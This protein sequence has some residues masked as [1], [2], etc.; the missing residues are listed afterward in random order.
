MGTDPCAGTSASNECGAGAAGHDQRA[1]SS[2]GHAQACLEGGGHRRRNI[3]AGDVRQGWTFLDRGSGGRDAPHRHCRAGIDAS[4]RGGQRRAPST[5]RSARRPVRPARSTTPRWSRSAQPRATSS[6]RT[7]RRRFLP[8]RSSRSS[9]RR[10]SVR[11]SSASRGW[12]SARSVRVHRV[13]VIRGL[14]G[15]RV[16][17]LEDGQ[18]VGDLS[19]QSGDHGVTLNPASASPHRS[20]AWPR[21]SP[22]RRER[23]RGS[24]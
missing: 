24:R 6:S 12:R 15:D 1:G 9:S 17:I 4:A 7:S 8:A 10:R 22:V 11:H 13:P 19:S 14:D 23:H 18:R 5:T 20:G 16:L 3:A 21:D 2:V